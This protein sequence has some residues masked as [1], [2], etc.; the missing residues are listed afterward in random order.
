MCICLYCIL[1]I[2]VYTIYIYIECP[3]FFLS[4]HLSS[5]LFFFFSILILVS[6]CELNL[7]SI[8]LTCCT[9]S[10]IY[11][12]LSFIFSP[13]FIYPLVII[14][15]R[16][17]VW[18]FNPALHYTVYLPANMLKVVTLFN[19][20]LSVPSIMFNLFSLVHIQMHSSIS[21]FHHQVV[22]SSPLNFISALYFFIF[23]VF[24]VNLWKLHCPL[25]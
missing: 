11:V 16:F 21:S 5:W 3:I 12:F 9:S 22:F 4:N 23:I 10:F 14:L 1:Y 20:F 15:V 2:F 7:F 6:M 18:P 24:F 25:L 19:T 17:L 13:L 8:V